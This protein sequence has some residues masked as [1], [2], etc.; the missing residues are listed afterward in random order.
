MS[1]ATKIDHRTLARTQLFCQIDCPS[2]NQYHGERE[3]LF[4]FDSVDEPGATRHFT[5]LVSNLRLN[6]D[7]T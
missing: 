7:V 1:R 3:D 4:Q 6:Q 2:D 5:R